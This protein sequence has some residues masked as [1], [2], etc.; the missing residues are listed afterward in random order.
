VGKTIATEG[1]V[2]IIIAVQ[3]IYLKSDVLK[4]ENKYFVNIRHAIFIVISPATSTS[5][6]QLEIPQQDTIKYTP[7]IF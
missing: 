1:Q 5:L 4:Q 2:I 7:K 3:G 6:R